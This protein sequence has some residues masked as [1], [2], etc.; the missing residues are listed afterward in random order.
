MQ[1]LVDFYRMLISTKNSFANISAQDYPILALFVIIDRTTFQLTKKSV[2]A[3][4]G[5]YFSVF[6]LF[7]LNALI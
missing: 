7:Y 6:L 1:F 2:I 4:S 5:T 3:S